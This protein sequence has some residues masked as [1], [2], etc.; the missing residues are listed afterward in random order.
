MNNQLQ[1]ITFHEDTIFI[2]DHEGQPFVPV[3]PICE[4]MG[5]DWKTQYRKIM[6]KPERFSVGL[7]P[8]QM[9]GDDQQREVVC[10][11]LKKLP[12]WLYSI[13]PDSVAPHLKEK[14]EIYQNECD[15][16]LWNYWTKGVGLPDRKLA[17]KRLIEDDRLIELLE[18]EGKFYKQKALP[19]PTRKNFT[20]EED[21][22][23]ME[24]RSQGLSHRLIGL[25]IGRK[26]TSVKSCLNRLG[27]RS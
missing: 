15:E 9:P 17:G 22:W 14:I 18:I 7:V 24:L 23:V 10:I 26:T 19:K 2:V 1:P 27:V 8:T 21:A 11:H 6:A 12:A 5:I 3:R 25:R 16:V 13:S 20:A 4:N